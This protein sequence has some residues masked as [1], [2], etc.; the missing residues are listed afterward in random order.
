MLPQIAIL[1]W[2]FL[3]E[4]LNLR[5]IIGLSLVAVGIIVVQVWRGK[6]NSR[7]ISFPSQK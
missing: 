1:A 7:E 4:S 6:R 2:I 3:G 5:Q